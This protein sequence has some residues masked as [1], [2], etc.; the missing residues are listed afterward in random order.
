[1]EQMLHLG[2]IGYEEDKGMTR[3]S[4]SE[5]FVR[6]TDYVKGLM[7]EAGLTV[8]TDRVGNVFGT[9]AGSDPEAKLIAFG[10]HLDSVPGGGIFQTG[11]YHQRRQRF[12]ADDSGSGRS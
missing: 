10:S 9:M 2:T 8:T 6:G 4:Y 12:A 11:G 1:M 7:E 5:E 3:M